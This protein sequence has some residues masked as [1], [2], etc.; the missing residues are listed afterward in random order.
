MQ[1][2]SSE[3]REDSVSLV[4]RPMAVRSQPIS[5]NG[6]HDKYGR[7]EKVSGRTT[8]LCIP[9]LR[10]NRHQR[11]RERLVFARASGP[12]LSPG[13]RRSHPEHTVLDQI[14][15]GRWKNAFLKQY[16]RFCTLLRK[17]LC[18]NNLRD[19]GLTKGL[20]HLNACAPS[21]RRSRIVSPDS[22][23]SG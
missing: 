19:F 7:G 5:G 18:S 12:F 3:P 2:H 14:Q 1:S 9:L 10:S 22:R 6:I 17:E 21:S 16:E 20:E 23:R 11:L 4:S 8:V 15:H 13:D